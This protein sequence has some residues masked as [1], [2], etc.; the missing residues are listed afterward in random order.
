[1]LSSMKEHQQRVNALVVDAG[2]EQCISASNDGS[3]IIWSLVRY[4][5]VACLFSPTQFKSLSYH[6][7]YAQLLTSG[8][9]RK[10]MY[11]DVVSGEVIRVMEGGGAP[12]TSVGCGGR[13]GGVCD[14]GGGQAGEGVGVRQG[15]VR[16]GG[17]GACGRGDACEDEPGWRDGGQ[18]GG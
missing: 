2:D 14:R 10:L 18:R 5:R 17:G 6:P 13:R 7:E 15:G 4:T 3:A 12:V 8:S 9:D 1:M 11:W 16:M